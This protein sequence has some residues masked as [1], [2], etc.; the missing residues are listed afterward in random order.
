MVAMSKYVEGKIPVP[1]DLC[2]RMFKDR[3]GLSGHRRLKHQM[4][5]KQLSLSGVEHED[6]G[7]RERLSGQHSLRR[8]SLI[9]RG[10]LNRSQSSQ[11]FNMDFD[12]EVGGPLPGSVME[13]T[14]A[15]IQ[16]VVIYLFGAVTGGEIDGGDVAE[17][18]LAEEPLPAGDNVRLRLDKLASATEELGKK[19]GTTRG[20][21]SQHVGAQRARTTH[22]EQQSKSFDKRL[23]QVEELEQR[24][25]T[26]DQRLSEV[27]ELARTLADFVDRVLKGTLV[28]TK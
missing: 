20:D 3:S 16:E 2:G 17:Y 18:V 13:E 26:F 6:V 8:A 27:E 22:L 14:G 5:S 15:S 21:V 9:G 24:T 12:T 10:V 28:I 19:L 25:K 1:C 11:P 7:D 4:F 23:S